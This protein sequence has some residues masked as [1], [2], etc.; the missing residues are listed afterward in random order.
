MPRF[1]LFDVDGEA[2]R[3]I[4]DYI[5]VGESQCFNARYLTKMRRP[6]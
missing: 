6:W 3:S 2:S 4:L 5:H 1:L